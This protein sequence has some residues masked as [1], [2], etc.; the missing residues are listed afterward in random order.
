MTLSYQSDVDRDQRIFGYSDPNLRGSR[1]RMNVNLVDQSDGQSV[2]FSA[3]RPFFS[4]DSR[5][6]VSGRVLDDERVDPIYDLGE[7]VDEFRHDTRFANIEGGLSNGLVNGVARRW[8]AG[9]TYDEDSFQP[10]PGQ[11]PPTLLP[12][13]RK[14]VYPWLG[15]QLI[16]DDF[17]QVTELNDIGRTEDVALGLNLFARVGIAR[18]SL[19]SDRDATILDFSGSRGW[20]PG[21]PGRLFLLR[22]SATA[23]VESDGVQNSIVT[24]DGQYYRRNFGNGLL[25]MSLRTVLGNN[26]DYENQVLLGGDSDLRGYPL[27]YQSGNRS[28]IMTVEQRFFTDWYPFKLIRVGYAFFFDAGRVWGEDPRSTSDLGTLYDTGIGL[29]LTSPR[30]SS[31]SVVHIDLAFPINAPADIDSVQINIER[32]ASF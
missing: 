5:W 15:L 24:I 28:A 31:G 26:L 4:L 21:G 29:R 16:G 1:V 9:F 13:D 25:T 7:I 23:R 27:R 10:A 17:R 6:S 11:P 20:E 8:I 32:K 12:L 3:G 2:G 14:L 22:T 19:G 18:S 30:S